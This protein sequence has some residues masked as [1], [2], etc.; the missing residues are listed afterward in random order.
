[1][2]AHHFT[3]ASAAGATAQNRFCGRLGETGQIRRQENQ[4]VLG[5]VHHVATM[6]APKI[7]K[8]RVLAEFENA[9]MITMKISAQVKRMRK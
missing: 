5:D 7:A 2:S 1:M 9:S 3:V 6:T 8:L 4:D